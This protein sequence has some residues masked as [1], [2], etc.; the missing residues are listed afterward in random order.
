MNKEGLILKL[1]DMLLSAD[2]DNG[3][4]GNVTSDLLGKPVIVRAND[5]G[6]H[7]GYY[8]SHTG[9]DVVLRKS[10]R[11]WRWWAK[12]QMTLS[13]VAEFG[14]NENKRELRIQCE[15][16][17]DVHVLDACEILPCTQ[18]CVDSFNMVEPYDEQ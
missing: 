2:S 16:S 18:A 9:R 12:K 3:K 8:V 11:M 4:S 14:L 13:A 15:M 10:R 1:I 6:V 17:N 5:A 7:F